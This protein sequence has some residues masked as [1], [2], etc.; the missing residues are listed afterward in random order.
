MLDVLHAICFRNKPLARQD[1]CTTKIGAHFACV[2]PNLKRV[3]RGGCA[4]PQRPGRRG[5]RDLKLGVV[6]ALVDRVKLMARLER[7][8]LVCAQLSQD[9]GL[10][11]YRQPTRQ[12][13]VIVVR[14]R[15]LDSHAS[16]YFPVAV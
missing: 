9:P 13:S 6:V 5:A 8:Q 3:R 2:C 7:A 15:E 10:G 11:P 4:C 12:S 16:K 14:R 1:S